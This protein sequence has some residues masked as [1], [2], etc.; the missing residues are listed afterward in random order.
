M[1]LPLFSLLVALVLPLVMGGC[2]KPSAQGPDEKVLFQA[3]E[4][5]TKA[6]NNKDVDGV[7]ATVHPKTPNLDGLKDF[8]SQAFKEVTLKAT[9]SDLKVVTSSPEEARVSFKQKTE[10]VTDSGPVAL[11]E[12]EGVHTLRPD[13]GKW[14]IFGT[15]NTKVTRLDQKDEENAAK[16][17]PAAEATS[18][19]PAPAVAP[20]PAPEAAPSPAAPTAP[21]APAPD[22][23]KPASPTE[24]PAQ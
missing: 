5:N 2:E 18:P 17:A 14:K 22:A 9:V 11:N 1:K 24:K 7:I 13:N 23:A 6:F 15:V 8:I 10:K 16:A 20:A 3:I 19:A 12:V 21:A 4:D